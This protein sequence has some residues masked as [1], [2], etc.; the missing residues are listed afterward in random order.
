MTSN[1]KLCCAWPGGKSPEEA[2]MAS[3]S[4]QIDKMIKSDQRKMSQE[5]KLLLLG[6][7]ESG[8]IEMIEFCIKRGDYDVNVKNKVISFQIISHF[9]FFY[10]TKKLHCL[11]LLRV[12]VL[13]LL[14]FY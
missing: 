13:K 11:M 1:L 4:K 7:G 8:K 6:A 5:V 9:L 12:V 10:R 14:I 3:K 2:E